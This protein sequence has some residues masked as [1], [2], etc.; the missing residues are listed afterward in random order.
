M[1]PGGEVVKEHLDDV[2]T[3][4]GHS[5]KE[6]FLPNTNFAVLVSTYFH[7]AFQR[8]SWLTENTSRSWLTY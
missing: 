5:Y 7:R 2:I 4:N 1:N 8:S 3:V 6:K